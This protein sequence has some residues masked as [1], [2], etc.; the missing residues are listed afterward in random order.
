MA[1]SRPWRHTRLRGER[2]HVYPVRDLSPHS[3]KAT[4]HCWCNPKVQL[5]EVGRYVV[6]HNAADARELV[7]R[8]GIN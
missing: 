2:V 6:I 5:V 8:H 3:L 7:E 1:S 4:G